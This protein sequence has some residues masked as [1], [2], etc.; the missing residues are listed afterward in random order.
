MPKKP[1]VVQIRTWKSVVEGW[2]GRYHGADFHQVLVC[3]LILGHTLNA[4]RLD[5]EACNKALDLRIGGVALDEDLAWN[6]GG[7]LDVCGRAALF[8][9]GASGGV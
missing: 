4:S 1:S 2:G 6:S 5:A 9:V 3:P 8:Y 7:I